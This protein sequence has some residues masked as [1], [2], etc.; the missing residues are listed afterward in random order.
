MIRIALAGF[1]ATLL[2]VQPVLAERYDPLFT[3]APQ[4]RLA[5][6]ALLVGMDSHNGQLIAV[7]ALGTI[8]IH[9]EASGWVQQRVPT[10]VLLTAVQ[11]VDEEHIWAVG[12]EGVILQSTDGGVTWEFRMDGHRLLEKEYE[13][14]QER[15]IYLEDA[16]AETDDEFE[17]EELEFA[18]DE[19]GFHIGGA[20]IQFDVGPTKPFLDVHFFNREVGLAV[21]A[22]GTIVRT[23]DGGASWDVINAAIDNVVG[24]HPN[25]LVTS[26]DGTLILVGESGLLARSED[27]GETFEMLDSP[28]HGSLF[29]ALYD[30][31][32]QL[33]I[34]GLR[35]NVFVSD[36]DGESFLQV[37]TNTR[38]NI[39]SGTV[40]S[41]GRVVLVG[42]SGVILVID[43]DTYDVTLFSHES[44][45]PLSSVRETTNNTLILTGRA[46]VQTFQLPAVIGH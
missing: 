25:K 13:W 7:G 1:F 30:A 41:D 11:V 24:Y 22:Y 32:G 36:D 19:L 6:Q 39:N 45:V 15:E 29:G 9:H 12:H 23:V 14:L 38:Y 34:Y 5:E 4:A 27:Q 35:G 28:Y 40:L 42:H 18:L 16:I 2:A 3:P 46:G 26:P 33:W 20:E 21:G 10:S 37:P 8:V 43:P 31:Q 17:R 44:N